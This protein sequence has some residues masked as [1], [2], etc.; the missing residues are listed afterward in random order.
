MT[1]TRSGGGGGGEM[2]ITRSSR[3][4]SSGG[5]MSMGGGGEMTITRT[6]GGGGGEMTMTRTSSSTVSS[7]GGGGEVTMEIIREGKTSKSGG[8]VKTSSVSGQGSSGSAKE[9]SS[10]SKMLQAEKVATM[11]VTSLRQEAENDTQTIEDPPNPRRVSMSKVSGLPPP[12]PKFQVPDLHETHGPILPVERKH[13]FP[14]DTPAR[15]ESK[16]KEELQFPVMV[17][18]GS[19]Q[20]AEVPKANEKQQKLTGPVLDVG[21]SHTFTK[22]ETQKFENKTLMGPTFNVGVESTHKFNMM[23]SAQKPVTAEP[24]V[25]QMYPVLGSSHDS[26]YTGPTTTVKSSNTEVVGKELQYPCMLNKRKFHEELAGH[27]YA[28]EMVNTQEG[29]VT[30]ELVGPLY[31][32]NTVH[33]FKGIMTHASQLSEMS[34][35]VYDLEAR[36]HHYSELG[37]HA[38]TLK[39]LTLPVFDVD[40]KHAY[41][42]I[43]KEAEK[44]MNITGPVMPCDHASKYKPESKKI[45]KEVLMTGPKLTGVQDK[46]QYNPQS[47]KVEFDSVMSGPVYGNVEFD[48][49]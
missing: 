29:K 8:S 19:H 17:Q 1:I 10:S 38:E 22:E 36:K 15:V 25:P 27:S 45:D 34:G 4:V 48:S 2:T 42:I 49:V 20:Y 30:T 28:A 11:E 41:D 26:K 24:D 40:K 46:N 44:M 33:A 7:G 32:V 5:E 23:D 43:M 18:E 12:G 6:G 16:S 14:R 3:T 39:N 31:D 9:I 47:T 35:P 37:K 21:H 13:Q